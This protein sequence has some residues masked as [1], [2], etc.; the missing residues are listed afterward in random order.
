MLLRCL[1]V[2]MH[3]RPLLGLQLCNKVLRVRRTVEPVITGVRVLH[4]MVIS[5]LHP[6][7]LQAC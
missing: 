1:E 4:L 5:L 2:G 7:L 6:R 3:L